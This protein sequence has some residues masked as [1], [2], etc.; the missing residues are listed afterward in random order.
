MY[1]QVQHSKIVH[2]AHSVFMC[3][4]FISE[5][6][7]TFVLHGIKL[8]VCRTEMKSAYCAA[9][10]VFPPN[11]R[12]YA[13][14]LKDYNFWYCQQPIRNFIIVRQNNFGNET[15]VQIGIR[16]VPLLCVFTFAFCSDD[17]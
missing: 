10:T 12:V 13:S 17:T 7:V 5:Q 3:F 14:P 8:L 9:R 16:T 6:T 15:F 11:K 4:I 2:S 1:Q